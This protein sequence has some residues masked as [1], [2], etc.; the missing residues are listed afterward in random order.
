M[1][2]FAHVVDLL[3]HELTGLCRRRLA[4]ALVTPGTLHRSPFWH[5]NTLQ[6]FSMHDACPGRPEERV[7]TR[8]L[9]DELARRRAAE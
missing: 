2:A 8:D 3:A 7:R 5:G 9:R 4:F 6:P 1:F